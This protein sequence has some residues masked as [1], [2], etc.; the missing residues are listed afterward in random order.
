MSIRD[1]LL[2]RNAKKAPDKVSIAPLECSKTSPD[3]IMIKDNGLVDHIGDEPIMQSTGRGGR[4]KFIYAHQ[5]HYVKDALDTYD[6]GDQKK[7]SWIDASIVESKWYA[8]NRWTAKHGVAWMSN[9]NLVVSAP[10]ALTLD[11]H[12]DTIPCKSKRY[13]Y[14]LNGWVLVEPVLNEEDVSFI[15]ETYRIMQSPLVSAVVE[16]RGAWNSIMDGHVSRARE[17]GF[18]APSIFDT[19]R[20]L[21]EHQEKAVLSMTETGGG[22]LADQVGLGKGGEFT[23][24]ALSISQWKQEFK[25]AGKNEMY[26][27]VMVSTKSMRDEIVQEIFKWN[28]DA[29]ITILN[30][31]KPI[32]IDPD[33]E[34]IVLH[35]DILSAHVRDILAVNPKGMVV[36]EAHTL[37]NPGTKRAKAALEVAEYIRSHEENP[38]IVLASG[39]PFTNRP[40]ELWS[41]LTI[42]G[43]ESYF[44]EYAY[45]KLGTRQYQIPQSKNRW[46]TVTLSPQRAFEMR[47]CDGQYDKYKKWYCGGA[48]NTS[49][50]N[51]LLL[52]QGM[53]RRKKSDVMH[54][55]PELDEQVVMLDPSDEDKAEYNE[56]DREFANWA[57]EQARQEAE[58][59]GISVQEALR[60][61]IYKLKNAGGVMRMT[62]LRQAA[63]R[64]KIEQ[65]I[66]WIH[67]FMSGEYEYQKRD[68]DT[69][70]IQT[71]R[72]G[73]DPERKK[74]IVFAY[75]REIQ[76]IL[77]NHPDL[78]QYG[79]VSMRSGE[80][81]QEAKRAF[82]KDPRVRLMICYS[83]A[84]EG[85]TLTAA[86]DV[87]IVELPFVPSWV[88]Q[89]AGR[90]WARIS[91][92][93]EPHE[94]TIWYTMAK[95]TIDAL[96]LNRIRNKKISFNQIIDNEDVDEIIESDDIDPQ[97]EAELVMKM[98]MEGQKKVN[99]AS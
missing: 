47:W 50:L 30:G 52:E 92:D 38:Y 28:R 66:D 94:A 57:K 15:L 77:M 73:D 45:K 41:L 5:L 35:V 19:D 98:I 37:K 65:T 63:A 56:I 34:F 11:E 91:E 72:I 20:T 54:P 68:A 10:Y 24:G 22:I 97:E 84:R 75:H 2:E 27:F 76:E 13:S 32:E 43:L 85:H 89:M 26:P 48:T 61:V 90:C 83:G 64:I 86:K 16:G 14:R 42:L 69:G 17:K 1:A 31:T 71:V 33:S 99:I 23:S 29:D 36:D 60:V 8:D 95:G 4:K 96:L 74:L 49:E 53:I 58:A 18:R 78:Q 39:T 93:F 51:R 9:E 21:K 79:M 80:D 3:R 81:H 87:L 46:K 59:E 25:N 82:Q 12:L 44:A 7:P 70:S 6:W 67:S 62:A 88:I 55:L 40:E